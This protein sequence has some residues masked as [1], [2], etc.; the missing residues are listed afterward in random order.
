MTRITEKSLTTYLDIATAELRRG[1][2]V[3]VDLTDSTH[4]LYLDLKMK[5]FY[6]HIMCVKRGDLYT[7]GRVK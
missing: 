5:G 4:K 6:P 7:L 2:T 3:P 1:E